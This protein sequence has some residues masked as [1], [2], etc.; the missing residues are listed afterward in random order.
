MQNLW[1]KSLEFLLEID[2]LWIYFAVFLYAFVEV[3]FPPFPGDILIILSGILIKW[4]DI[5]F[6]YLYF[7]AVLG[8]YLAGIL[9]F[10]LGY[11]GERFIL[12]HNFVKY[13]LPPKRKER[14]KKWLDRHS[15]WSLSL[16]R[17]L[18]GIR[19]GII[20]MAGMFKTSWTMAI[21]FVLLSVLLHNG[22]L[23]FLGFLLAENINLLII[24]WK[25]I[26]RGLWAVSLLIVIIVGIIYLRGKWKETSK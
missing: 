8:A 5:S 11:Y 9:I 3:I 15:L 4:R 16:S 20:L 23:I 26:N 17:F 14:I 24:I 19:S 21:I 10:F 2:A 12:G 22:L 1:Y 6:P 25:W 13:I 18:P 7:Y